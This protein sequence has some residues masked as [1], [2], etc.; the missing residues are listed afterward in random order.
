M[1]SQEQQI[2][3]L[4][5]VMILL[6]GRWFIK[7]VGEV[8]FE[9]ATKLNLAVNSSIGKAEGKRLIAE[10]AKPIANI[11]E[12]K[13]IMD[14]G[15][16]LFT[17]SDHVF[18]TRVVDENTFEGHVVDCAIYRNISKAGAQSIHKCAAKTR[19]LS[20]LEGFGLNGD[21]LMDKDTNNC[22]GTC[23]IIFKIKWGKK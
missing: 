22:N 23:D 7:C 13:Q 2:K 3:I 21:V 14:I 12:F 11:H 5:D 17:P 18:T 15:C 10:V 16:N 6:D 9:T 1:V 4:R 19:F 8:G 20:W